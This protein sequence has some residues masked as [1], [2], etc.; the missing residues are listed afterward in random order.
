MH[1]IF[2]PFS[3]VFVTSLGSSP[4]LRLQ[5]LHGV[6]VCVAAEWETRGER[7]RLHFHCEAGILFLF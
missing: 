3:E 2:T 5:F 7:E 4:N 1:L 6:Y